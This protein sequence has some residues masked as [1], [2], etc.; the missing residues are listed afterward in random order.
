MI[1]FLACSDNQ[2]AKPTDKKDK[3]DFDFRETVK[4]V[5]LVVLERCAAGLE[6][7]SDAYADIAK[8]LDKED[9]MD[10]MAPEHFEKVFKD[11]LDIKGD[12]QEP[13]VEEGHP[14]Y[15]FQRF[16][17][18]LSACASADYKRPPPSRKELTTRVQSA[19]KKTQE[20]LKNAQSACDS[21]ELKA[22]LKLFVKVLETLQGDIA[23]D[24]QLLYKQ[25]DELVG[26][27]P[28]E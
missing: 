21:K 10:L 12:V 13:E 23:G 5:V 19:A 2:K 18:F 26:D 15:N 11:Y 6:Y 9:F 28:S 4:A 22:H 27:T 8:A 1:R 16:N 24:R 20:Q 25:I 3:E 7:E 14:L 17:N